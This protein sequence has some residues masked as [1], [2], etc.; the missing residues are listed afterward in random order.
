[1]FVLKRTYQKAL[2][3]AVAAEQ[4]LSIARNKFDRERHSYEQALQRE[5]DRARKLN[6]KCKQA[7]AELD[8]VTVDAQEPVAK[9]R[10]VYRSHKVVTAH[11][12]AAVHTRLGMHRA[13]D[14]GEIHPAEEGYAPFRV[15]VAY[16]R[17]HRPEAGGYWVRYADGYESY[18][19]AEPFEQGYTRIS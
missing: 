13:V 19:P 1:M 12:I 4:L 2:S 14:Y 15:S 5:R 10:P 6:L 9:K 3:D 18:S 17:K 7:Q 11:K 8:R 16:M